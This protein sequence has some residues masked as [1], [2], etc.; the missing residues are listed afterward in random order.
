MQVMAIMSKDEIRI[1][2]TFQFL[3]AV[4]NFTTVV[5]KEAIAKRF[6]NDGFS[7]SASQKPRSALLGFLRTQR[8]RTKDNPVKFQVRRPI[9]QLEKC[10][11]TADFNVI[12]VSADAQ[13]PAGITDC[14]GN[15]L[16]ASDAMQ[17]QTAQGA[18]PCAKMS[19]SSCFSL[20]VSIQAQ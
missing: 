6:D 17:F 3:K 10:R 20:K 16:L 7:F 9:D 14:A 5:R 19:S 12:A 13:N 4:F 11:T 2:R 8:I 15:Q 1:E 18:L